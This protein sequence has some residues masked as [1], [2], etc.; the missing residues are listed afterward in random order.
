MIVGKDVVVS[1]IL[2]LEGKPLARYFKGWRIWMPSLLS[3]M[4]EVWGLGIGYVPVTHLLTK[5]WVGFVFKSREHDNS[6]IKE[7]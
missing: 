1:Y 3:W 5:G 2:D 4:E 7:V 6:F